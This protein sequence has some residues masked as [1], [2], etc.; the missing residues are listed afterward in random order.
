MPEDEKKEVIDEQEEGFIEYPEES[1]EASEV[2]DDEEN[3]EKADDKKTVEPEE[4]SRFTLEKP[5]TEKTTESDESITEIVHNGQV[6]K[7][8]KEKLIELAQKGFDYDFK[9]GPHGKIVK[10]IEA[11]PEIAKIVNER[12]QEKATG[13]KPASGTEE[14]FKVKGIDEYE[15][16]AEWLQDNIKQAIE[17]GQSQQTPVVQQQPAR[18]TAV[19]DALKMRDPEHSN[20]V[21]A[22]MP[23]YAAQLSVSDYGRIDS[24]MGALCQ[25]YD[26]VK[27][28]E[29]AKTKSTPVKVSTP[30]FRVKSGGGDAPKTEGK[31][32]VAWKLSRDDF[33][34]Q[35]DKI[36]LGN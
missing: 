25:F 33:Q 36:K 34:K 2:I 20:M 6:H 4:T 1:E 14:G 18:N 27:T 31:Q 3:G 11:D 7:F 24:D 28:K 16:E 13:T 35:L 9:V 30:G 12:W 26:F 32:D 5:E 15:S 8:T 21:I 22:A 23:T 19:A 29:L 17:F 10:M